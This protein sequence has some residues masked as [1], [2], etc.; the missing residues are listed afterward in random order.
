MNKYFLSLVSFCLLSIASY[1]QQL[2]AH[3][4]LDA[5]AFVW[6]PALA[7]K[8]DYRSLGIAYH[9][10]WTGFEDA[11]KNFQVF[12]ES[13]IFD[14]KVSIGVGIEGEQ[15]NTYDR[16][17]L[18]TAFNY[19]F[20]MG[21]RGRR[22]LALGLAIRYERM[23]ININDPV[24]NDT[25]DPL[26]GLNRNVYSQLNAGLGA[27]FASER[28]YY[29]LSSFFCGLSLYPVIPGRMYENRPPYLPVI[30]GSIQA[31]GNLKFNGA[32]WFFEPVLWVDFNEAFQL[33]PQL[34]LKM[35]RD[36][37]GWLRLHSTTNSLAI[38]A[39]GMLIIN[40]NTEL[41]I[42]LTA[43]FW[44]A[45]IRNVN[46]LGGDIDFVLRERLEDTYY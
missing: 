23:D 13:P 29:K 26:L 35:E 22:Q 15:S 31:G 11:P 40:E 33:Y 9:Q 21:A 36:R 6:N 8:F 37:Y 17:S 3:Y 2:P 44:Y 27:F 4:G 30:H 46:G 5:N 24:V 14:R 41:R 28:K 18:T 45:A 12:G 38:N 25:G 16:I 10:P 39:G 42:G 1:T 32:K 7:G 20:R 34:S 43:R 19:K